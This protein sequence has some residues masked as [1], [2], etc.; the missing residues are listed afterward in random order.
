VH[1]SPMVSAALERIEERADDV[2]RAFTPG[3]QPRLDDVGREEA[4]Y[5][6]LD[7]LSV[8]PPDHVYFVERNAA[9]D[10][11][12]TRDGSFTVRDGV[13]RGRD[14]NPVLGYSETGGTLAEIRCDPLDVAL[15]RV[16]EARVNA[17][18]SVEYERSV[19]DPRTGVTERRGV[20]VGRVA[21]ARFAAGTRLQDEGDGSLTA[22]AGIHPKLG[23]PADDRFAPLIPMRRESSE[24]DIDRGIDRLRAAYVEFDAMQ[25]IYQA[26]N[27]AAKGAM[28]LVK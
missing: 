7:T 27:G 21:L 6:T 25:A 14:G 4:S 1:V 9:G 18:G 16:G 19:V 22:P 5:P 20:V 15:G 28:D 17:D 26:R 11:R 23:A 3:A 10:V 12:Y 8:A 24:I 13:L 2:R